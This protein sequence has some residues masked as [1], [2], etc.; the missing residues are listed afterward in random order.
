MTGASAIQFVPEIQP[1]VKN[2]YLM[3]RTA[4]WILPKP[5]GPFSATQNVLFEKIPLL[6]QFNR[7]FI[8]YLNEAQLIGF[9]Y[10]DKIL[11]VGELLGKRH[12]NK[13]IKDPELRKN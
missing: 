2:L 8:Y 3:Q 10:N 13:Y 12:I 6:Q 9:K 5:D 1:K 7:D 4:P 11:K